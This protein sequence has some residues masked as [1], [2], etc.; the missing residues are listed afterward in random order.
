[1]ENV[2]ICYYITIASSQAFKLQ[3]MYIIICLESQKNTE[4]TVLSIFP[5]VNR[6]T[7]SIPRQESDLYPYIWTKPYSRNEISNVWF[8]VS[9]IY[10]IVSMED[11]VRKLLVFQRFSRYTTLI[12]PDIINVIIIIII[13][14]ITII[15][16]IIIHPAFIPLGRRAGLSP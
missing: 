3:Y 8:Y 15:I 6:S 5:P 14:I 13:I 1:M 11:G 2:Y 9:K 16:I 10:V 4:E 12:P 7:G